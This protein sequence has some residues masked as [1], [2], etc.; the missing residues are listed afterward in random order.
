MVTDEELRKY[1]T[2][3]GELSFEVYN[4][5]LEMDVEWHED[6]WRST[7]IDLS[8]IED[9]ETFKTFFKLLTNT[10]L[11]LKQLMNN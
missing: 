3:I 10:E 7:T 1:D 4:G 6:E 2:D 9:I 5:K 8:H 11:K